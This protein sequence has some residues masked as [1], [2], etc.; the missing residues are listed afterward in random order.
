M[1]QVTT[2]RLLP[3]FKPISTWQILIC[4]LIFRKLQSSYIKKT[5]Q[6]N[7]QSFEPWVFKEKLVKKNTYIHIYI[8]CVL[9]SIQRKNNNQVLFVLAN[10]KVSKYLP[11]LV[12]KVR[13]SSD[14]SKYY[15]EAPLHLSSGKE[16]PD[17]FVHCRSV[18]STQSMPYSGGKKKKKP[19]QK[20]RWG[21]Y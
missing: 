16:T 11:I 6:L 15:P 7:E 20:I 13:Q 8:I 12:G 1:D 9:N 5:Q 21:Y 10:L 19:T 14:T 18:I 4:R 2:Y 3:I 17:Y